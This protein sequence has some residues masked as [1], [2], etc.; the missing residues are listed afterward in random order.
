MWVQRTVL[1]AAAASLSC[2]LA[3]VRNAEA[4]FWCIRHCSRLAILA[5]VVAKYCSSVEEE[6]I[7]AFL[8]TSENW[9]VGLICRAQSRLITQNA[10]VAKL[11]VQ[12][13]PCWVS[14]TSEAREQLSDSKSK[15]SLPGREYLGKGPPTAEWNAHWPQWPSTPNS[16]YC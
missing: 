8:K 16:P 6:S 2:R 4:V 10:W 1:R 7:R 5:S 13:I 9:H 14:C 12:R 3:R 15:I 11:F